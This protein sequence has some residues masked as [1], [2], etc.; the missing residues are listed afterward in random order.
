MRRIELWQ[1]VESGSS[2]FDLKQLKRPGLIRVVLMII[3]W[4][5][6]KVLL[7][8][9][10]RGRRIW[11]VATSVHVKVDCGRVGRKEKAGCNMPRVMRASVGEEKTFFSIELFRHHLKTDL[12]S[13]TLYWYSMDKAPKKNYVKKVV[14]SDTGLLPG[15]AGPGSSK[16]LR[17]LN[18]MQWANNQTFSFDC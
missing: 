12:V 9:K 11:G 6:R 13:R 2:S 14:L 8:K 16:L 18:S 10:N 15:I 4:H 7:E 3:G 1:G 5:W 17:L